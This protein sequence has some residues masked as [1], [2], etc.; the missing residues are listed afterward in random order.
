MEKIV[1]VR[2]TNTWDIV[3]RYRIYSCPDTRKFAFVDGATTLLLKSRFRGL[4]R[5]ARVERVCVLT[6]PIDSQKDSQNLEGLP[7]EWQ[8]QLAGY[9]RE[10]SRIH[11]I[12]SEP[13]PHRFYLLSSN[14]NS[15]NSEFH[16]AVPGDGAWPAWL[17]DLG[18]NA[19]SLDVQAALSI[20]RRKD[21]FFR[22]PKISEV[23]WPGPGITRHF[24]GHRSDCYAYPEQLIARLAAKRLKPDGR[25]NGPAILAYLMAGG[26]R[27]K[28]GGFG[29]PIHHIYDGSVMIPGTEQPILHAVRHPDYF[30]HS[31]GLV[32]A[33]PAAHLAAHNSE[34]LGWL[35]RRE[36]FLLFKFDPDGVFGGRR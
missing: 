22:W 25:N 30:T 35:L 14:A 27:P 19:H 13:C 16:P 1:E 31:G 32:A 8:D 3:S 21:L 23:L 11:G 4:S 26:K 6:C 5:L 12:L 29:W 20:W 9:V 28:D 15:E 17:K 18:R 10:A 7:N 2:I 33:H 24:D 36:A 34:L